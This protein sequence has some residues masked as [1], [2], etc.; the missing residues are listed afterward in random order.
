MLT[1][2]DYQITPQQ[3]I[4]SGFGPQS[5]AQEALGGRDLSGKTVIVTGG[6]SGIGLETTRVLA[7]AGATVIVPART[8]EKAKAS[9][10]GIPRVELEELD[11][12]DPASIDAFAQRFLDSGR[13]LDILVNNAGI[14]AAPLVRDARGYESQF[15]TNHLGHFQ[16]TARLWPALK[17]AGSARVVSVSSAGIRF[18]GVDFDDPNFERR[19]YEKWSAYGQSKSANA[20]FA[21]G[22][23]KRGYEYGIRAFS[24][25]PGRILTDLARFMTDDE[26]RAMGAFDEQGRPITAT[27]SGYKTVQQGAATSVWCAANTQLDGKGGVYCL[28]ADIAEV[29]SAF[30][31]DGVS[32]VVTGV[33]PWAIDPDLS[34]RLWQL[35]EDMTGI[36]FTS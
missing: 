35:S 33:L 6:Y 30:T 22:L 36:K 14:M 20:L 34:E 2:N 10:D 12:L 27:P 19:E 4:P 8:L 23:D 32:Q 28:D 11:L 18:G 7:E 29:D 25:H 1:N 5:T 15:A 31:L 3:P 13:A 17:Q 16:L 24:V 26:L 9:L 21:V